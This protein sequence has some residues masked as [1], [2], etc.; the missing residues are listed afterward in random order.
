MRISIITNLMNI[1]CFNS[2]SLSC[3]ISDIKYKNNFFS[4]SDKPL[5]FNSI[6]FPVNSSNFRRINIYYTHHCCRNKR[7]WWTFSTKISMMVSKQMRQPQRRVVYERF[8]GRPFLIYIRD[9]AFLWNPHAVIYAR[10]ALMF[11]SN[12]VNFSALMDHCRES[13]NK[14][15]RWAEVIPP[16]RDCSDN[17]FFETIHYHLWFEQKSKDRI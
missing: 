5:N 15:L 10:I 7:S 14:E 13:R 3:S 1:F 12:V 17:F 8:N 4:N 9:P 6:N 16:F 11:T 2:L